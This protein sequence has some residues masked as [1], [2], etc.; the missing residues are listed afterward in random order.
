MI[1]GYPHFWKPP[2]KKLKLRELPEGTHTKSVESPSFPKE[3]CL[4]M[5][6]FHT[7]MLVYQ[8][9]LYR[10]YLIISHSYLASLTDVPFFL[11]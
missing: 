8:M 10:C 1:R 9:D 4:Q 7:S 11:G 3:T 5:V 6:G 2:K